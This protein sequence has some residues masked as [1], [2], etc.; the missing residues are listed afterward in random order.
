[1]AHFNTAYRLTN[2]N[3]GGFI[4]HKVSEDAGGWTFA[5]IAKN[6]H[7]DWEGWPLVFAGE[8]NTKRIREMVQDFYREEYWKPT[9]GRFIRSQRIANRMYDFAV[10]AGWKTAVRYAQECAG[11]TV[12]GYAG[13]VTLNA[14]NT[15][16]ER[17]FLA[18][19]KLLRVQHR[20]RSME[21]RKSQKKFIVGWLRRDLQGMKYLLSQSH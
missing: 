5:G 21:R 12:D 9:G 11:V 15:M 18:L 1:M 6:F 7:P 19:F 14:I 20:L 2:K 13:P 10:N 3:E 16:G 8:R 17:L 4:L